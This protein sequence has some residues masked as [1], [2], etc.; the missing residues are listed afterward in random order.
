MGKCGAYRT[1]GSARGRP[2]PR[3]RRTLALRART[4]CDDALMRRHNAAIASRRDR[5]DRQK[6]Y[7]RR[8]TVSPRNGDCHCPRTYSLRPTFQSTLSAS[9]SISI[10]LFSLKSY[11]GPWT[12]C[13]LTTHTTPAAASPR[14]TSPRC[15]R[16]KSSPRATDP[17]GRAARRRLRRRNG[18]LRRRSTPRPKDN[19]RRPKPNMRW[20]RGRGREVRVR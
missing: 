3:W 6:V 8:V 11:L 5:D 19:S 9:I 13:M 15:P 10:S 18:R 4:R 2:M 17:S 16:S 20:G 14:A 12:Y 1:R 7:L